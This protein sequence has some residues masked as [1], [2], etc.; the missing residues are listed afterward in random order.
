MLGQIARSWGWIVLRGIIAI[1]FG[2]LAI[3]QPS[4]TLAA[5]VFLWGAYAILDG[6]FALVAGFRIRDPQNK[7]MWP[8]VI[9]GV[10]G[11][12]A[13]I[14]TFVWPGITAMALL[15]L[16]AVWALVV[17]FLQIFAAYKFRK[18]ISNEWLLAFT[19]LLSVAFG[20]FMLVRPGAGALAVIYLIAWYAIVFGLSLVMLGFRIK[21]FKDKVM[22][23]KPATA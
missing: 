16:I 5:L 19:G 12:A 1:V 14:C 22:P 23:T 3:M 21:G 15:A 17:G 6:V 20:V 4:I 11:L 2:V 13:G 7:P 9:L 10:F 18:Y 8:L